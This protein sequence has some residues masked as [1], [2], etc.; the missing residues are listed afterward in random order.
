MPWGMFM[1]SKIHF[2]LMNVGATFQM[3]MDISFVGERKEFMVF[4]LDDI[5]VY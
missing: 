2:G 4:Y 5:R 1:Y 3:E